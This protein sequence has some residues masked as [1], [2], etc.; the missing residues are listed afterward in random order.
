MGLIAGLV[1]TIVHVA[2]GRNPYGHHHNQTGAATTHHEN[3]ITTGCNAGPNDQPCGICA[4]ALPFLK[5]RQM[6]LESKAMRHERRAVRHA[7]KAQRFAGGRGTGYAAAY[8][9]AGPYQNQ[10]QNQNQQQQQQQ[11]QHQGISRS[12]VV[13]ERQEEGVEELHGHR[14]ASTGGDLPPPAYK[15]GESAAAG[16][17]RSVEGLAGDEKHADKA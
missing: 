5:G 3:N 13:G 15:E 11:Q 16:A 7:I 17:R 4:V 6:K 2:A 10:N 9:V 1:S 14:R 8:V 12:G